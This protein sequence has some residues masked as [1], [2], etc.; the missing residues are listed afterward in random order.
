M[1]NNFDK[2]EY[3]F[4]SNEYVAP[5]IYDDIEFDCNEVA[6]QAAKCKN[7]MDKFQFININGYAAKKLSRQIPIR[8]DWNE[9]KLTVMEEICEAKFT[10]NKKLMKTYSNR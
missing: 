1:I 3:A 4:L 10:Q 6:Y 9:V 2:E 8:P 5:V 7:D